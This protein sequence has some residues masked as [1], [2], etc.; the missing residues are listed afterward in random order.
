M[1]VTSVQFFYMI[2]ILFQCLMSEQIPLGGWGC[3]VA[4]LRFLLDSSFV[5]TFSYIAPFLISSK[6]SSTFRSDQILSNIKRN[7]E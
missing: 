6:T 5:H 2:S 1:V 7:R 3:T 4:L